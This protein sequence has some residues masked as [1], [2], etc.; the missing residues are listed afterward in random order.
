MG[1]RFLKLLLFVISKTVVRRRTGKLPVDVRMAGK[2][3]D[4]DGG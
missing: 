3:A 1:Q 2:L 4:V